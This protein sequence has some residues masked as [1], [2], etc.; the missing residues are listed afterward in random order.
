MAK[1]SANEDMEKEIK[2]MQKHMG[3]LVRTVLDLKS[4]MEE[5]ENKTVLDLK[6]KIEEL[7]NKIAKRDK[8]E[9]QSIQEK[10]KII[11]KAIAANSAAISKID[12]EI[13]A[14]AKADVKAETKNSN[15]DQ[16][17]VVK[18][19]KCRYNNCGFCKYKTKCRYT[20]SKHICKSHTLNQKCDNKD[21]EYRHPAVC[22]W[23]NSRGWCKR[24][25][26]CEYLHTKGFS[27]GE[28]NQSYECIS[29]K[30]TWTDKTCV[31][32]HLVQNMTKFF[33]LNCD[34]WVKIKGNVLQP[35]W[36]LLDEA[37]YLRTD[38]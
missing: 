3:G 13:E 29:C 10:Q 8:E 6:S 23:F 22:K 30:G 7:E 12:K 17:K 31:K 1:K 18:P 25:S 34:D 15:E 26:E 28:L 20:H 4:K 36:T 38:I 32:E 19:K 5:L 16:N 21:C 9:I 11:D 27:E 37:G 2:T 24:N 35:G 14:A 33:C